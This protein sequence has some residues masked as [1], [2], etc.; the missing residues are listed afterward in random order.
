[1]TGIFIWPWK[2][3]E[4]LDSETHGGDTHEIAEGETGEMCL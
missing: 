1:M 2:E 4:N 3:E